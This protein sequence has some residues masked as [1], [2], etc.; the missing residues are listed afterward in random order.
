MFNVNLNKIIMADEVREGK[1][2]YPWRI[3]LE[4]VKLGTATLRELVPEL[5]SIEN[6]KNHLVELI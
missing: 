6:K 2:K 3:R 5:T 1:V 4:S